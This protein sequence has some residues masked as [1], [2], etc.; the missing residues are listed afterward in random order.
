MGYF[1]HKRFLKKEELT[2]VA[3]G[4]LTVSVLWNHFHTTAW[5]SDMSETG[6]YGVS[7][8]DFAF[9]FARSPWWC[10]L[11]NLIIPLVKSGFIRDASHLIRTHLTA[12]NIWV[13]YMNHYQRLRGYYRITGSYWFIIQHFISVSD[14][15][16]SWINC[17]TESSFIWTVLFDTISGFYLLLFWKLPIFCGKPLEI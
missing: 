1:V 13:H 6:I 3:V 8:W 10:G 17:L 11:N 16:I 4:L 7:F 9:D 12:V 5:Y 2:E 15:L 14:I